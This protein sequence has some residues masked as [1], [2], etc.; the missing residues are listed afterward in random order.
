MNACWRVFIHRQMR[1]ASSSSSSMGILRESS[2]PLVVKILSINRTLYHSSW[3]LHRYRSTSSFSTS[4]RS[5]VAS[6]CN[7]HLCGRNFHKS[8]ASR[9]AST[10]SAS[11]FADQGPLLLT[12]INGTSVRSN[13]RLVGK[14]PSSTNCF[15]PHSSATLLISTFHRT[16]M[17][18]WVSDYDCD[19]K[20]SEPI[21]SNRPSDVR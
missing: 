21:G 3:A 20:V 15:P 6:L 8:F 10:G 18:V 1:S 7:H 12:G 14:F 17:M 9:Y 5:I 19:P 13:P 2:L 16:G 11:G 4:I